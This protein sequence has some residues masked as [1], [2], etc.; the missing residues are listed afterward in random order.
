[1][2]SITARRFTELNMERLAARHGFNFHIADGE[3]VEHGG[4]DSEVRKATPA[5]EVLWAT[6]FEQPLADDELPA[7]VDEMTKS[8][9]AY[10]PGP[11]TIS[12]RDLPAFHDLERSAFVIPVVLCEDRRLAIVGRIVRTGAVIYCSK[13]IPGGFF[14]VGER[15]PE[16]HQYTPEGDPVPL[17]DDLVE[18]V[19]KG[20][21][22][23]L[24]GG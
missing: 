22:P 9:F 14:Y 16:L 1:M 6:F 18:L 7:T 8:A 17:S 2:P 21:R 13:Q 5:E 11:F 23:F 4:Y 15:I 20:L 12:T 3:Y 19:S 24:V 10:L